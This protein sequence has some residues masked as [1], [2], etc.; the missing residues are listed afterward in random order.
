MAVA[1]ESD[2]VYPDFT[3]PDAVYACQTRE[4]LA[5]PLDEVATPAMWARLAE[6]LRRALEALW[7]TLGL[8]DGGRPARWVS[9]NYGRIAVN[10]H[11]W[12]R[13]RARLARRD[14][15]P[16]LLEPPLG[17]GR[18]VDRWER[19]RAL[20]RR[21]RLRT[22]FERA[23]ERRAAALNG[24][25]KLELVEL[26]AAALARG[27]LDEAAWAEIL[28]LMLRPA[29]ETGQGGT[30]DPAL[31]AGLQLEQRFAAELGRRLVA[32]G[33]LTSA[34]QVAYLTPDER[35]RAV[36]ESVTGWAEL[37]EARANRVKRFAE[38]EVPHVFWGRPRLD[39]DAPSGR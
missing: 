37:A 20:R 5:S 18:W 14:P 28:L 11:G 31:H 6:P 7:G 16:S 12:E 38:L 15:D 10:A 29:L 32:R 1:A 2:P 24:A 30:A 21:G 25:G 19:R 27:P 35:I 13:L 4:P 9:L 22:R 23:Q 3:A 26:D 39:P 36:H 8:L 17:L 33:A 34:G